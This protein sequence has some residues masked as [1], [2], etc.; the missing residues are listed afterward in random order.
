MIPIKYTK[1]EIPNE[2]FHIHTC[3]EERT[4]QQ[5]LKYFPQPLDM[6]VTGKRDGA[7]DFRMFVS[8][9]RNPQLAELFAEFDTPEVRD[10]FKDITGVDCSTGHLRIELCQDASGFYLEP[11][12]D[13]PEKLITLQIYLDAGKPSWGTT[14]FNK[15]SVFFTVPFMHNQGW[16]SH[17]NSP[18]IHGVQQD[19]VS[20]VRK[21]VIINYVVGDWRDTAQLY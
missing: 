12:I 3:F 9:E 18:L 21:S 5:I 11:H 1:Y 10:M 15:K 17:C 7:N 6:P 8:K 20:D 14:I 13:I 16:M 19:I 4:A 2:W